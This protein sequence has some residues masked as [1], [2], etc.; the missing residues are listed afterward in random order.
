MLKHLALCLVDVISS[1]GCPAARCK[2]D[3]GH[4]GPLTKIRYASEIVTILGHA[5][6]VLNGQ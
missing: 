4:S 2:G 3:G 1:T 6:K 5:G